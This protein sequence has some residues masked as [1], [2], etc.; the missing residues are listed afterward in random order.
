[1][2]VE[3]DTGATVEGRLRWRSWPALVL[4]NVTVWTSE[5]IATEGLFTV[6]RRRVVWIQDRPAANEKG[7]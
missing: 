2:R 7:V 4:S 5:P 6:P 3:L 1:M